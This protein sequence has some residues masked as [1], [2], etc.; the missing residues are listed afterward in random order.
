MFVNVADL[1]LF[2]NGTLRNKLAITDADELCQV[3]ADLCDARLQRINTDGP[4]GPFT[5]ERLKETHRYL[6]QDIYDWAGQIRTI[7]ILKDGHR[8]ETSVMIEV[9]G[10]VLTTE[11][12]EANELKGLPLED[13]AKQIAD[14]FGHINQ[15]H[16]F[17]EGNG[18]AQRAFIEALASNAKHPL[19][20]RT[21]SR[22]RMIQ[23]SIESSAGRSE[24]MRR[25]FGEILDSERIAKLEKAINF[26]TRQGFN[27]NDR[28]IATT[29]P[30]QHY[31]GV[32]VGRAGADVMLRTNSEIFIG[33]S[34]DIPD[35]V[36]SGDSIVFVAK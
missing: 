33:N 19:D 15:L 2:S 29:T 8:F 12:A 35:T 18:R 34:T 7:D 24:M 23:A 21:V 11:L 14:I 30:G 27:W 25:I 9:R 10:R 31:E 17:R 13:F 1:Y 32:L 22:E 6:F 20:F 5:F 3:E 36:R 16:P 4:T 28:Y 26:L